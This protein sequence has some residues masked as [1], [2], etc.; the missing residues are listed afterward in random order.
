MEE[1]EEE[2]ENQDTYVPKFVIPA[3]SSPYSG[4]NY[5]ADSNDSRP[6]SS[7]KSQL[8]EE[9]DEANH[10]SNPGVTKSEDFDSDPEKIPTMVNVSSRKNGDDEDPYATIDDVNL[11]SFVKE[12]HDT[13]PSLPERPGRTESK[14]EF[15][16]TYLEPVS[17]NKNGA[18]E[19]ESASD[20]YQSN[21]PWNGGDHPDELQCAQ[22]Q[23]LSN[24]NAEVNASTYI[25]PL[26][27]NSSANESNK[28]V[29]LSLP[30]KPHEE[31]HFQPYENASI[32]SNMKVPTSLEENSNTGCQTTGTTNTAKLYP[33][34]GEDCNK[35]PQ[36]LVNEAYKSQGA[37]PKVTRGNT[38][39]GSVGKDVDALYQ[40][41]EM[42]KRPD[43][44]P[45][46]PETGQNR[47]DRMPAGFSGATPAPGNFVDQ[48]EAK[49]VPQ[50]GPVPPFFPNFMMAPLN[51]QNQQIPMPNFMDPKYQQQQNIQSFPRTPYPG[52][53]VPFFPFGQ[54]PNQGNN[55][56]QTGGIFT[57]LHVIQSHLFGI[58]RLK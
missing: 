34:I 33:V 10:D 27:R 14:D 36:T 16:S 29:P 24:T 18:K 25:E 50:N 32:G 1:K 15:S 53:P 47:P 56:P 52:F 49:F 43:P 9:K 57:R 22:P 46:V 38:H 19:T 30:S 5:M 21:N 45:S 41:H 48:T 4:P 6:Y 42:I 13:P 20:E 44:S 55:I 40:N 26:K 35:I 51:P 23:I 17:I 3:I 37:I 7:I 8:S 12:D 28:Q 58:H 54:L 39:P 31:N 2:E 11:K